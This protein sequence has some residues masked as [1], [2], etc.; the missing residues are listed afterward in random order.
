MQDN[1]GRTKRL[2]EGRRE[3]IRMEFFL[4]GGKERF[5][6]LQAASN[7]GFQPFRASL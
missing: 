6:S 3:S 7:N 4:G 5:S 1:K 2:R